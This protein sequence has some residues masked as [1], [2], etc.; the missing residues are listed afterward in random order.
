MKLFELTKGDKFKVVTEQ[1]WYQDKVFEFVKIDG[2]YSITLLDGEI[3]H[4]AAYTT[5]EKVG[6]E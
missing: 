2:M 3:V 1:S 6:A 5:V 4:L